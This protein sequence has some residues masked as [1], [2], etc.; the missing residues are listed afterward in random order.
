M[1]LVDKLLMTKKGNTEYVPLKDGD[2]IDLGDKKLIV[3]DFP[4]HTPGS[5]TLLDP[6][7][8]FIYAGDASDIDIWMFTNPDCSLH[9]YAETGTVGKADNTTKLFRNH[10]PVV[11]R[12]VQYTLLLF[13]VM[14]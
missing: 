11:P 7:L 14:R 9:T 6:A 5:I 3:K 4:G 13:P 8:K 1:K 10:H 2:E 12:S